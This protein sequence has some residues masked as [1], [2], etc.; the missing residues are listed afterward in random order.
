[1]YGNSNK[2]R[3]FIWELLHLVICLSNLYT[4]F[5]EKTW[6]SLLKIWKVL[7]QMEESR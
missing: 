5:M 2:L 4:R 3:I 7:D 6:K 1:M